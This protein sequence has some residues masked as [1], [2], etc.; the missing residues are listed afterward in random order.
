MIHYVPL[1]NLPID[2]PVLHLVQPGL[3]FE[4]GSGTMEYLLPCF[5]NAIEIRLFL[6]FGLELMEVVLDCSDLI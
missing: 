2:V 6:E 5:Q 4:G 1:V 3:E